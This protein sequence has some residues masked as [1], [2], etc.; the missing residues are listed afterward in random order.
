M[1]PGYLYKPNSEDPGTL[2]GKTI[3]HLRVLTTDASPT[4]AANLMAV[5]AHSDSVGWGS[6]YYPWYTV[7]VTNAMEAFRYWVLQ[8][9]ISAEGFT[10]Y[11]AKQDLG[12]TIFCKWSHHNS[13]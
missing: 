1:F 6:H 10:R 5:C 7:P 11:G 2:P 9:G 13:V 4:D 8:P 3:P 12:G